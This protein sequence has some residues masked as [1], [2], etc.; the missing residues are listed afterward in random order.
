MLLNPFASDQ[1]YFHSIKPTMVELHWNFA[2]ESEPLIPSPDIEAIWQAMRLDTVVCFPVRALSLE[3]QLAHL[4]QHMLHHRF[5]VRARI[6]GHCPIPPKTWRTTFVLCARRRLAPLAN[7]GRTTLRRPLGV[8]TAGQ[9]SPRQPFRSPERNLGE[10]ARSACPNA[11]PT[12]AR[13]FAGL[14]TNHAPFEEGVPRARLRL[15]ASRIFMPRAYLTIRYPYARYWLCC[16]SSGCNGSSIWP[17][18]N[19]GAV[20]CHTDDPRG[21]DLIDDADIRDST[22]HRLLT[23]TKS[24]DELH[25]HPGLRQ[26]AVAVIHQ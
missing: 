7:G 20:Y 13:L 12:A 4:V 25:A 3:D 15:I 2:S 9:P 14:R 26:A 19:G 5:A 11:V 23:K 18:Q 8:R 6:F 16:H 21:Y 24:P 1:P 22:V 10:S 17:R